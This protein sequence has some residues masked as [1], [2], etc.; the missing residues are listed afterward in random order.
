MS[1][2]KIINIRK[3]GYPY[4]GGVS[5]LEEGINFAIFSRHATR[6]TLVIDFWQGDRTEPSRL[7]F[8]LDPHEN[9][10]GDMWH[11][12][13]TSHQQNFSYGYRIDGPTDSSGR[14][15]VYDYSKILIDPYCR[16]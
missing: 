13:L 7:E 3:R 5:R 1:S 2:E 10:T 12:L 4:P 9:R 8:K 11:I 14:G 15:Q 6:V 16:A